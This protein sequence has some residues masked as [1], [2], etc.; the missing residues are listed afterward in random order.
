MQAHTRELF[1]KV[2]DVSQ[3]D[4]FA[5][6][7]SVAPA[8]VQA[9]INGDRDGPDPAKLQFDMRAGPD[10]QWNQ[11]VL[12]ILLEKFKDVR[13]TENWPL[14]DRSDKYFA[15]LIRER[16]KR[17]ATVWHSSQ[18]RKTTSGELE[19]WDE[20]EQRLVDRKDGQ[21]ATN[22]HATRRRNVRK[23]A[24]GR[25]RNPNFFCRDMIGASA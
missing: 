19:T 20:V 18:R 25:T 7:V 12:G 9:Y 17:A 4:E 13:E 24:Q 22:R 8:V 23:M 10:S 1:K 6:Y 2:F 16:F 14:P 11:R 5:T 15:D 3:D 21:L